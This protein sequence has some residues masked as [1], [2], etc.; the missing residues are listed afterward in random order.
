MLGGL[1]AHIN[2]SYC[3]NVT[4]IAEILLWCKIFLIKL[5]LYAVWYLLH[6]CTF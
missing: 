6:Y 3:R 5:K 1:I 2:T 4:V